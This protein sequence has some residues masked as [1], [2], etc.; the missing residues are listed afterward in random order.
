MFLVQIPRGPE[1]AWL[2][3]TALDRR[4]QVA[5]LAGHRHE[6]NSFKVF[7]GRVLMLYLVVPDRN[8]MA[9]KTA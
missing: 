5:C 3:S 6:D 9:W 1:Q 7:G 4:A 2:E 8:R